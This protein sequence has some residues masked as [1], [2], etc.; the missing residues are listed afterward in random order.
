[1]ALGD[2]TQWDETNPQQ[3][4]FANTIDSYDR[5]LRTGVRSRMQN[6]HVWPSSQTGVSQAGQHLFITIQ[7]Q[8]GAPALS[9]LQVGT[10]YMKT[11][12][13]L[14]F[15]NTSTSGSII[16]G[17]PGV[18]IVNT[19]NTLQ[20]S[21]IAGISFTAALNS[22]IQATS[23]QFVLLYH[24]AN[25]SL[26]FFSDTST[27]PSTLIF[28][29]NSVFLGPASYIVRKGNYWKWTVVSGSATDIITVVPLGV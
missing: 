6:E 24:S 26:N 9:G 4:T 14:Y 8:T 16:V 29:V 2:G 19:S 12:G 21:S 23:D 1:M 18:G 20:V 17:T 10:V 25:G 7:A 11:D 13:N 22:N 15:T 3:S 5:D 28:S 27:N